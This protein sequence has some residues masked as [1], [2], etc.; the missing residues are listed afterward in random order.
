ME[1][2]VAIENPIAVAGLTLIPVAK[3]S[4]NY[5]RG[6]G[7]T[8]FFGVKQPVGVVV[9]YPSAKRAFRITGEEVTLD[10]LIQEVPGIEEILAEV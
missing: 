5:W 10:Q 3:V 8:S 4:L 6:G 1:K 7:S 9:V 2:K